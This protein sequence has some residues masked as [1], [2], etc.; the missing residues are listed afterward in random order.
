MKLNLT[1][2]EAKSIYDRIC[3]SKSKR[4]QT[5]YTS[6]NT[7][8]SSIIAP[9]I[10]PTFDFDIDSYGNHN[11]L[12]APAFLNDLCYHSPVHGSAINL[13][14]SLTYGK[15]FDLDSITDEAVKERLSNLSNSGQNV[16][17]IL[18]EVTRDYILYGGFA[19]EIIYNEA[20]TI[21][22]VN[23]LN[24]SCVRLSN[25]DDYG[26]ATHYL[27]DN[28]L[29]PSIRIHKTVRKVLPVFNPNFWEFLREKVAEDPLYIKNSYTEEEAS[30]SRQIIYY[31]E[32]KNQTEFLRY[33]PLPSYI[34][35]VNA[36]E[37][38]KEMYIAN[39]TLIKTG[40]A[41]QTFVTIKSA[42]TDEEQNLQAVYSLTEKVVGSS[43]TGNVIVTVASP[44]V[45]GDPLN[46][47]QLNGVDPNY[48]NSL[49]EQTE[50]A[51]ATAH[52]IP[53]IL[54]NIKQNSGLSNNADERQKALDDF[55]KTTIIPYQNSLCKVFNG[56]L[57]YLG[58]SD[59]SL[60]IEQLYTNETIQSEESTE[61]STELSDVTLESN[62]NTL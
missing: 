38:D 16:N 36:I 62:N 23:R 21:H 33:Y 35:G 43:A 48:Y 40:S 49:R 10:L 13:K 19:L 9:Y 45:E 28:T 30:N 58:I 5:S 24:F 55:M 37:N 47:Q 14:T 52:N 53:S 59:L 41:G 20:G 15:G 34:S 22:S 11:L 54:L 3:S 51:I 6:L 8:T 26:N 61:E 46:I 1:Y 60:A 29:D 27:Y 4:M 39:K 18:K 32:D 31:I 25:V 50:Q 57:S 42:S 17:E 56:L 12:E 7:I 2:T 44:N